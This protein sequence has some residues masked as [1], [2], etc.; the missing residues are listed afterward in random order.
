MDFRKSQPLKQRINDYFKLGE[1]NSSIR[2]EVTASVTSFFTIAYIVI[3][4]PLILADAG[5]PM[6]AGIVAT[7]LSTMIGSFLMGYYA[8]APVI[9]TPGMGVNAFFRIRLSKPWV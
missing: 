6:Q 3:V 7:V 9:V 8:N 5:I 4:N 1:H 2:Q